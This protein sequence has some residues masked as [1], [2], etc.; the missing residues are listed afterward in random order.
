[1][2]D[3][4]RALVVIS[5]R[6]RLAGD[7]G[8][9]ERLV[10]EIVGA[11]HRRG[12]RDVDVLL[13]EA[14][15]VAEAGVR[16][17]TAAGATLVVGVG[18]DGLL[19]AVATP[20]TGSTAVL[21]IVPSGT[22]NNLAAALGIPHVHAAALRVLADGVVR[23]IDHGLASWSAAS[24]IR[25]PGEGADTERGV[26][27]AAVV[28]PFLVACGAGLDARMVGGASAEAKRR[29]GLAAYLGSAL[30]AAG[31]LAPRPT[32]LVVDGRPIETRSVVVLVANAGHLLPG[33]VRPRREIV[34]D[35]GR[36]DVFVVHG[37]VVG[38]VRG[39]LELLASAE[40]GVGRAGMRLL[41]EHVLVEV[42]PPEP[43][44]LDGDVMGWSPLLARVAPGALSVI[45]PAP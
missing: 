15:A 32:R 43:V 19:R 1:M 37:G 27:T 8:A 20:L 44:Q 30:A 28:S 26:E 11:A 34:P 22:G 40:P 35:D 5:G 4:G 7:P 21:A 25:R 45:V 14:P 2:P 9:R 24:S 38:S 18:G 13:A 6:A 41:A 33:L 17:A 39:A 10:D 29:F 12:H 42:D 31:D 16:D 23:R 36:L 3:R